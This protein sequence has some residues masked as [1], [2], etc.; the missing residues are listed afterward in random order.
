MGALGSDLLA[1]VARLN[2]LA[3]QRLRLSLPFAQARLLA[4]I[5]D[6]GPTRI[7]DL[8][9][10]DHTSQPTMTTQVRRLENAGYVAR[11]VDPTDARA[12][13]ISITE[14]GTQVLA[15]LRADRRATIR[16]YLE[17]LDPSER[18]SLAEA[19]RVLR[20]LLDDAEGDR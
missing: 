14:Q 16:P 10:I 18:E 8:A 11:T 13:L 17:H 3:N 15:R 6:R 12:V 19:I 1:V 4:T 2:R 5:E 20:G 7:T 9:A